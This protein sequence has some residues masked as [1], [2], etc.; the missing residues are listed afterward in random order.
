MRGN[1]N[2]YRIIKLRKKNLKHFSLDEYQHEHGAQHNF[3]V[4]K[5]EVDR[6]RYRNKLLER[7]AKCITNFYSQIVFAKFSG[8]NR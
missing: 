8:V 6:I 3:A 2:I 5:V 4:V 1:T 7:I